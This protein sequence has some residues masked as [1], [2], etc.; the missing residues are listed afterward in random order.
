[1]VVG[2]LLCGSLSGMLFEPDDQKFLKR[3]TSLMST[4]SPSVSCYQ[5]ETS[6]DLSSDEDMVQ[7]CS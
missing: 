1:M 6:A 2:D 3:T 5:S 4:S 7:F